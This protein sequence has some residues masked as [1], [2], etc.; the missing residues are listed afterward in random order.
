LLR[1]ARTIQTTI[2]M[3]EPQLMNYRIEEMADAPAQVKA[4]RLAWTTGK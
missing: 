3:G 1:G 4:L 2:V